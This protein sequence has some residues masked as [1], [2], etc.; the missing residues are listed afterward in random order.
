MRWMGINEIRE[1]YL[2]F[3][4]S[5]QHLRLKSAPLIPIGDNSLLL[6]NAGMAPLK[7]YFQGLET[8]PS[9][10]ATSCQ[11]CIRTIDIENVGKTSRHGTF[12]EMLG[13]FSFGDY[14]K[15]EAT[16]WAWEYLTKVLEIPVDLLWVSVYEE[17][18]EAAE[19]WVNEVG[20]R[21][22]RIVRMGKEDNFWELGAGPCGPCSEIYVDRGPTKGCGKPDC[23]VECGCDRF[24]EVWNL[25]FT[26]F[27]SDGKGNYERL[28]KPNIDTGMGLERLACVLQGVDNLF[29]TD[30]IQ[31]IMNKVL[32]YANVKYKENDKT[33]VSIR[34][35]TEHIRSAVF[36]TGDGIIPSNE[37]RGYILRRLLR[38]AARHGK[39]LGI[40][41]LY[42]NEI[43]DTV[44]DVNC[45]AYPELAE[46]REY[47]KK[48]IKLEEE[49]FNKNIDKGLEMLSAWVDKIESSRESAKSIESVGDMVFKLHDTY[50]FP[51]DITKEIL[52][53]RSISIDENRFYELMKIQRE[54][55]RKA[56]KLGDGWNDSVTMA[57]KDLSNEFVGY[58]NHKFESE[59]IA[60]LN[61]NEITQVCGEGDR[62]MILLDK[63]PFYGESGGQVG[64]TGI[65]S[66]GNNIL[67]VEDTKKLVSGQI[68]HYCL[69]KSGGFIKGD[70][71]CSEIDVKKRRDTMRNH[72]TAHIL[73]AA[74]RKVLG[75]HVH[76][77]GSFVDPYRCRFDFN[78]FSSVTADELVKIEEICNS[79]ILDA[80]NVT[81][82]EMPIDKA[83]EKGAVALFSEKYGDMVRVVDIDGYS[84]EFCGG[85]HVSNTS[86]IGL[87]K[88]ISESSVAAGVR[89][90]EAVSG[91][92]VLDAYNIAKGAISMAADALRLT[93]IN[94]LANRCSYLMNELKEKDRKIE[95]LNQIIAN[96]QSKNI[97]DSFT[98]ISGIRVYS[99]MIS[100]TNTDSLRKLGDKL[101]ESEQNFIAVLAGTND[102][103]G[104][105][106]CLC[107][108]D[109]VS[110]GANAGVIVR[111]V[112]EIAGGKGGG[113]P[114]SAMAGIA[115]LSKIDTALLEV[116]KIVKEML[117]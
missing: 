19:I 33:D 96:S 11:K 68:I 8:P 41:G 37:G 42:L 92:G 105:F 40:K 95:S 111:K 86:Q 98:E 67:E 69:V 91:Q 46:K 55:A 90:I 48:V 116:E 16:A 14:F 81:V 30:T 7:R 94:E 87:M 64:D 100:N 49:N 80:R 10:R 61:N 25:V 76:Q 53:E 50:G 51:F 38:R 56:R 58:N 63:T 97:F 21:P 75:D 3:F 112:A 24:I 23:C 99:A 65:I 72:T 34:I 45:T 5:K 31:I 43:C 83:R 62:V 22:E 114:D 74:L 103:K 47:I 89:R 82:E 104:N 71:V 117:L 26:Q 12:F 73:Q 2:N 52:L 77:E 17:D 102:G 15:H 109:A 1:S 115:D 106:F 78:H 66:N 101:K 113:K 36:M 110:K 84:I 108:K 85:T 20:V 60:I 57:V 28:A 27:D 107:G 54:Q 32:E 29:E 44:I 6:I 18:D 79:I 93:N 35:I 59:I 4:E 39:L 70:K 9:T 13:N 88:I